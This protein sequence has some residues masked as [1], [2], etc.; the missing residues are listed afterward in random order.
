MKYP[1]IKL[2]LPSEL[3]NVKN[4]EVPAHLLRKNSIGGT[5]YHWATFAF[6]IMAHEA[7]KAGIEFQN[8]GDFRPYAGQLAMFRDRYSDK[9]TGR[10]PEV[11]RKFE[12]KTWYLKKGKAPSG[13]PGTSNHG[14]GLAIDLAL[15]GGKSLGGNAKAMAW[16]CENAPKYGFYL[17]GSDPKSPEFEAWHWQYAVGDNLP[18]P[19][20]DLLAYFEAIN[21][22]KG[23]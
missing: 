5:M 9:P 10:V 8:I 1:S 23:K 3:K 7:K 16:M 11:T 17:Q 14:M 13:T 4:G 15:K 19:T 2:V 20:K 21:A 18:Q 12:G 6:D 22:A